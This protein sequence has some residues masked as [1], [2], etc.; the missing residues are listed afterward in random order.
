MTIKRFRTGSG[1]LDANNLN[2]MVQSTQAVERRPAQ[3]QHFR[4]RWYGPITCKITATQTISSGKWRYT[5]AEVLFST[6]E[7]FATTTGG[8]ESDRVV[9]LAERDNTTTSHSGLVPANLQGFDL[10]AIPVGAVV[11]CYVASNGDATNPNTVWFNRPGEFYG[12]CT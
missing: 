8:F 2:K 9:N 11:A 6:P 7:T 1:R 12:T 4:P 10:Q 3:G 5:V